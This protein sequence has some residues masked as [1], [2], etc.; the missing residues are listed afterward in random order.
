MLQKISLTLAITLMSMFP[1]QFSSACA[2]GGEFEPDYIF[3]RPEAQTMDHSLNPFNYS[4]HK[5]YSN[6]WAENKTQRDWNMED[7]EEYK[8]G[9][10][11]QMEKI[12]YDIPLED[13]EKAKAWVEKRSSYVP[14][15][16]RN[17]PEGQFLKKTK[18]TA[19][20]DYVIYARRCLPFVGYFDPWEGAK[21]DQ[22]S[23]EYL[24]L[25]GKKALKLTGDPFLKLRYAFQIIRLAHYAGNYQLA[26]NLYDGNIPAL[27]GTN[28]IVKDWAR[29]HKAGALRSIGKEGE[30]AYQFAQIFATCPSR[31]VQAYLSFRIKS[32]SEYQDALSLCKNKSEEA[33][34]IALRAIDP[35]SQSMEELRKIHDMDPNN[36]SLDLLITRE[37]NKFEYE[38][39][40]SKEF[41]QEKYVDVYGLPRRR[42]KTDMEE[43][44]QAIRDL[45]KQNRREQKTTLEFADAYLDYLSGDMDQALTK[46][47][48]LS[49]KYKAM[50]PKDERPYV[51]A[52][53]LAFIIKVANHSTPNSRKE[54]E[55]YQEYKTIKPRLKKLGGD[56]ENAVFRYFREGME[57]VYLS[58]GKDAL[59]YLNRLYKWNNPEE[60]MVDKLLTFV[61]KGGHTEYEKHL[62]GLNARLKS[63]KAELLFYK[64]DFLIAR[65]EVNEAIKMYEKAYTE[66]GGENSSDTYFYK[67]YNTDPF[68]GVMWDCLNCWGPYVIENE[69][70]QYTKLTF[71][72]AL[73]KKLEEARAKPKEAGR[74]YL[75]IGNA[76]YNTSYYGHSWDFLGYSR[77]GS[78]YCDCN[79][80][81]GQAMKYYNQAIKLS[82][83]PEVTAQA[84]YMAAKIE[85]VGYVDDR[86][87]NHEE[88][89]SNFKALATQY[90]ETDFYKKAL[91]ECGYFRYYTDTH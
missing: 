21:R 63:Y 29:S 30:A 15:P 35:E 7:W 59:A 20:L 77:S 58:A 67:K 64:G 43:L 16:F 48:A 12:I 8:A 87:G 39:I 57:K 31:R 66:Y 36:P 62:I 49:K 78:G 10:R 53:L 52:Q 23:M 88:H 28:S 2:G 56:M 4:W 26:I 5:L 47:E 33:N 91:R 60:N 42:G 40:Q 84:H 65:G 25:E 80:D 79:M 24:I 38:I 45:L 3:F 82:D 14:A 44:R 32:E 68:Y 75:E 9:Y 71:A 74:I 19:L 85:Y 55:L 34:I 54:N 51:Q 17:T 83:D 69:M 86:R 81:V 76:Y 22:G 41:R 27:S 50:T 72:R 1:L 46:A 18:D 70:E 11:D 90:S 6:E 61:Y 89:W 37:L 13:L 73:Q